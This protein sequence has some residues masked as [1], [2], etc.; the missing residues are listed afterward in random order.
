MITHR[1]IA[2]TV[3]LLLS[4]WLQPWPVAAKG[5]RSEHV[6]ASTTVAEKVNINTADVHELMKLKGIGRKVAE[7]IVEY[8]GAHGP[9]KSPDDL[10]NVEGIGP[11][12][13]EQ[14]RSRIVV[15]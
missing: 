15:K 1:C 14:H 4:S 12:L 6:T 7:R 11:R 13:M 8:R 3:L 9:F 5:A 10:R 2:L